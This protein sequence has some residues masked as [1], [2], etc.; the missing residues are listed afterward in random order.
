[1][2]LKEGSIIRL[3]NDPIGYAS[4]KCSILA[5]FLRNSEGRLDRT[6]PIFIRFTDKQM[7]GEGEHCRPREGY[8]YLWDG[9][10]LVSVRTW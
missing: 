2:A 9:A 10:R 4:D 7:M 6:E 3:A 8:D 1:M 5:V